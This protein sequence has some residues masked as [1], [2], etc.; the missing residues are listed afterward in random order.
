[1]EKNVYLFLLLFFLLAAPYEAI[2]LQE[3]SIF[4]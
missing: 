3:L 4:V 1:M 2:S